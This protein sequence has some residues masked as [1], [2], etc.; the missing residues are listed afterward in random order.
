MD[1]VAYILSK[2]PGK[3]FNAAG[4][5]HARCPFHEDS[6]PSFS[7]TS[8]GL[9]I[10]GS[11]RCG[12]HGNFAQFYKMSEGATWAQVRE[13]LGTAEPVSELDVS[14]LFSAEKVDTSEVTNPYPRNV[15]TIG[16]LEYFEDR[17]FSTEE[18]AWLCERFMLGYGT[19]GY[20]EGVKIEGAIVVPIYD[21]DGRY[22]TFQVRYL[23]PKKSC[24]WKNP[25]NS[26]I[27][28]LLYGGWLISGRQRHVWIVEGASDV[29]NLARFG[30]EAVGLFTKTATVGQRKRLYDLAKKFD[31]HYLVCLDGD[32]HAHFDAYGKDYCMKVHSELSAMGLD[33]D[34]VYLQKEDDPGSLSRDVVTRLFE[35]AVRVEVSHMGVY[36]PH[37]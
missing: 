13:V 22:R 14:K 32:A 15:E 24:R 11:T 37:A 6:S 10:C 8:E 5:L 1:K 34:I 29:W 17:G 16:S 18:I 9:F 31:L 2:F 30:F 28:D 3:S 33:S 7:I 23:D 26:P 4:K 12:V 21:I 25:L 19:K 36:S 35:E 20:H 27:Q